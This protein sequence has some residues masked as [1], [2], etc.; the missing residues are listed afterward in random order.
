MADSAGAG[1]LLSPRGIL[2]KQLNDTLQENGELKAKIVNL[3]RLIVEQIHQIGLASSNGQS[4]QLAK[5]AAEARIKTLEDQVKAFS[6]ESNRIKA[7]ESERDQLKLDKAAL[8]DQARLKDA[9]LKTH[10]EDIQKLQN[11]LRALEAT[12]LGHENNGKAKDVEIAR[13]RAEL[14]ARD[15]AISA[16]DTEIARLNNLLA[17]VPPPGIDP[18]THKAALDAKDV[19]IQNLKKTITAHEATIALN[20]ITLG[21]LKNS[22]DRAHADNLQRQLVDALASAGGYRLDRDEAIRQRDAA[23]VLVDGLRKEIADLNALLGKE[24]R[25][26]KQRVQETLESL[27][28]VMDGQSGAN[29]LR[30]ISRLEALRDFMVRL[31]A[32]KGQQ[33]IE[34]AA[35]LK[36]MLPFGIGT[37][38]FRTLRFNLLS[39]NGAS[40]VRA[41]TDGSSVW[42]FD[43]PQDSKRIADLLRQSGPPDSITQTVYDTSLGTRAAGDADQDELYEIL[44]PRNTFATFVTLNPLSPLTR[45]PVEPQWQPILAPADIRLSDRSSVKWF[46]DQQVK[47]YMAMVEKK[48]P[49]AATKYKTQS[50]SAVAGLVNALQEHI[51]GRRYNL[52]FRLIDLSEAT[53]I[54]RQTKITWAKQVLPRLGIEITKVSDDADPVVVMELKL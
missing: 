52:T 45:P 2:E 38:E 35:K 16:R 39:E 9:A 44:R 6:S 31:L 47:S 37:L 32:I 46:V 41:E 34:I 19:E 29:L 43:D 22:A 26:F 49:A 15:A 28:R 27:S 33:N 48:D 36:S 54:D 1:P 42:G 11:Q 30:S 18:A 13:L 12:S 5:E 25:G 7:L 40:L 14:V 20:D 3:E 10:Q 50:L 53:R 24:P 17:A 8:E 51:G 23:E 21:L 4:A